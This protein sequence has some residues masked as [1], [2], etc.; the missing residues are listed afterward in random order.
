MTALESPVLSRKNATAG[1]TG[2]ARRR[3][4]FSQEKIDRLPCPTNGQRAYYY[5]AKVRGLAVAVAPLGKKTFVLYRKVMGRPQ[6]ITIGPYIDLS[7]DQ[8]R[9]EAERMN[10][11]IALGKDPA[12]QRKAIR[13]ESTVKDL[14]TKYLEQQA[15]PFQ[16]TWKNDQSM[17]NAHLENWQLRKLSSI[18]RSDVQALHTRIGNHSGKTAA[19]RVVQLLRRLFEYAI[20]NGWEGE[21]PAKKIRFFPERKRER[22]MDGG[23]L[24]AFFQSLAE[25]LNTTVR[26]YMLI[27]L[28]TGARRSNV[29][30]MRW[31]EIDWGRSTWNISADKA[32]GKESLNVPLSQIALRILETR[33]AIAMTEWVFPGTGKTGHLVEPKSAWKR[34]LK[35]AAA[36]QKKAWME[37]N[38]DATEA[39]FHRENPNTGFRDLRLHDLRRTLGS[40]QA[41]TGASLP[42]IGKSLGHKSLS[43]TQVYARL[44]LDPVRASVARATDAMLIAGNAVALLGE[45]Q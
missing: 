23:E 14:F 26:D 28:L 34:L 32:K 44:D 10:A 31:D 2:V 22:F 27:S 18:Q 43:A 33:K 38:S 19:N 35:N 15:K 39:D 21:N 29:Q 9:K 20:E 3:F 30:A 36:I 4:L 41:A 7:V 11:D 13:A 42:I 8:A 24:R 16:R 1:S 45:G 6:R 12:A 37:A 5:D 40:W 25:E 17:Y